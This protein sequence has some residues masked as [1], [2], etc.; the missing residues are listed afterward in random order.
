MTFKKIKQF[1]GKNHKKTK[2]FANYLKYFSLKPTK[3]K[4]IIVCFDGLFPHGGLVDRLKGII[5]FYQIA[6]ILGYDFKIIFNNPFDLNLFL[7]PNSVDWQIDTSKM[8]WHPTKSKTVYLVNNFKVNPLK[9]IKN[10]KAKQFYVYANIDYGKTIFPDLNT[11]QLENKWRTDFNHLFKKSELLEAKLN[12]ITT[13][14]FISFHSRFTTLMG[15]FKDSTTKVLSVDEQDDL[16]NNLVTIINR[17]KAAHNKNAFVFSDSINFIKFVKQKVQVSSIEGQP[18][19]MD[20]FNNNNNIDGHLKT[21]IDFF[22]IAKSDTVYFLN[23]KPMYNSSFSKYAAIVGQ[24]NFKVL[25][26]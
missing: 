21:L 18:F 15:D 6:Q 4:Q 19:H 23:V 20:N 24:T 13:T 5:S 17:V 9:L 8:R 25:E 12:A 1:L 16:C 11:E 2:V 22:M 26:A 7:E 10:S 3:Q 14:P